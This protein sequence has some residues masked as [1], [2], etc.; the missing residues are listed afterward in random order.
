MKFVFLILFTVSV[1]AESISEILIKSLKNNEKYDWHNIERGKNSWFI[2]NEKSKQLIV[3]EIPNNFEK[4]SALKF[5]IKNKKVLNFLDEIS[6]L[7]YALPKDYNFQLDNN[8]FD[9]STIHFAVELRVLQLEYFSSSELVVKSLN[10]YQFLKKFASQPRSVTDFVIAC[11]LQ[12]KLIKSLLKKDLSELQEKVL[13][14]G[15]INMQDLQR[16]MI[17]ELYCFAG[18]VE[19][20]VLNSAEIFPDLTK[21]QY[22]AIFKTFSA[23]DLYNEYRK[24]LGHGQSFGEVKANVTEFFKLNKNLNKL[25]GRIPT[26]GEVE[27][28]L[29]MMFMPPILELDTKLP[30]LQELKKKF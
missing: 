5:L 21:D 7:R 8:T 23:Q 11:N 6:I 1:R 4:G 13:K 26:K 18:I 2:L 24:L 10:N 9:L 12:Q 16:V 17:A 27:K 14:N 19:E 25:E 3:S 28:I 20:M 30:I 15:L 22:D 29:I